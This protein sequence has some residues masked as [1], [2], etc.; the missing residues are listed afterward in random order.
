MTVARLDLTAVGQ[1]L[2]AEQWYD[3]LLV[4]LGEDLGLVDELEEFWRVN[5]RLPPLL[6]WMR[7]L[8]E[9]VLARCPGRVVI[10]VDEIDYVRSLP[11]STDELFAAIR[12]CYNRRSDDP[13]LDRQSDENLRLHLPRLSPHVSAD[14]LG[15][16]AG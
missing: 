12:E 10:F 5:N 11:F 15:P 4:R 13:A 6:R 1:N 14:L 9:V 7:A 3:G 8:R 16:R 2:T